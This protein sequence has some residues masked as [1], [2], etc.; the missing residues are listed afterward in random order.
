MASRHE[1]VGEEVGAV[2]LA[3]ISTAHKAYTHAEYII[4]IWNGFVYS[5]LI[6]SK[7]IMRSKSENKPCE[8][9]NVENFQL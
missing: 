9:N 3:S 7:N 6:G 8:T 5:F 4:V 1:V 2:L